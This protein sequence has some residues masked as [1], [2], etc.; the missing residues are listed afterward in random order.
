MIK[1]KTIKSWKEL[2]GKIGKIRY[3]EPTESDIA[4]GNTLHQVWFLALDKNEKPMLYLMKEFE[5]EKD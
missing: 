5:N 1:F 2:D 4:E 3:A